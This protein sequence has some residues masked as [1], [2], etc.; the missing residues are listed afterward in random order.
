MI[1][2]FSIFLLIALVIACSSD[3]N[4]NG[5]GSGDNF[6]R[7]A[8]LTNWADNI[9]IPAFQSFSNDLTALETATTNFT[10]T[11]DQ[12]NLNAL[13]TAWF[14][15][16]RGWQS[17]ELFNIGM[18]ESTNYYFNMN[19]YP[20]N[21]TEIESNVTNGGYDLSQIN[22]YDAQGFPGIDYLLH[23][24]G[25]TDNEI[26]DKFSIDSNAAGYRT[27]LTDLVTRMTTLTQDILNDWTGS[28]RDTFV[29]SSGNT[30]TSSVN[31][32]VNDFIFYYEKGLRANKIG[33]PA[34]VFSSNTL[35][36]NVEAFYRK[37]ISKTLTLDG[38]HAV[39][40]FFNG[41]HFNSSVTGESM[42]SYLDYLNTIKDGENLSVLIT[43]QFNSAESQIGLLTDDYIDQINT[44]NNKM[45]EAYDQ[46]Q[47]AVVLIKVDMLQA[48]NISVD[49][50]DA[51]GD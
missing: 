46:L 51:D 24:L 42:K 43:N 39:E 15:A 25:A 35:P 19:T 44:N 12:T 36:D 8:M 18:A 23:G 29:N 22:S 5:G 48:F 6:D 13:R 49:F 21:A 33:I 7:S 27:Y 40:D 1:K 28:Y 14:N 2:K 45:L 26:L 11:V 10:G 32:L 34:G 9:I 37:D 17:V 16:Y 41:K 31:K 38:L 50:V 30:A 3:D 47:L 20:S 4:S